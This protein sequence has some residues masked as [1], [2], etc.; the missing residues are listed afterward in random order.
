MRADSKNVILLGYAS[1]VML[2]L[3]PLA[4]VAR[5]MGVESEQTFY[6][7]TTYAL[8]VGAVI[9]IATCAIIGRVLGLLGSSDISAYAERYA[10]EAAASA[11]ARRR[12]RV[13]S[14][15]RLRGTAAATPFAR[16]F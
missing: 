2:G 4:A 6:L 3:L 5:L 9:G 14:R 13:S 15:S 10:Q 7:P 16:F 11:A 8:I 1:M 12:P